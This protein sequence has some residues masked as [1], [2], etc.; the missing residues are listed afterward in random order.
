MR[1]PRRVRTRRIPWRRDET[2]H[3]NMSADPFQPAHAAGT[4]TSTVTACCILL[5]VFGGLALF[6]NAKEWLSPP[7]VEETQ[8]AMDRTFEML[9]GVM[10]SDPNAEETMERVQGLNLLATE[11]A[12]PIAMLK[13]LATLGALIGGV[14]LW[15][16]RKL[17]FHVYLLSAILWAFAPMFMMG[18]NVYSWTVAV[19]YGI[20]VLIFALLFNSQRKHML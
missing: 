7:S 11:K 8:E 16:M 20:V 4:R 18:A 15:R 3:P 9:Q 19:M 5:F 14:L 6:S 12:G 10:E 13:T 17:G 1:A 2:P